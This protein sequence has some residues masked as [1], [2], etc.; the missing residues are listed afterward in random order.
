M[1]LRNS[2]NWCFFFDQ[3]LQKIRQWTPVIFFKFIS[4]TIKKNGV[5]GQHHELFSIDEESG[6][7]SVPSNSGRPISIAVEDVWFAI[8]DDDFSAHVSETNDQLATIIDSEIDTSITSEEH[9]EA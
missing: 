1:N 7:S 3:S 8:I 6:I 4:K 5:I 9:N 2:E